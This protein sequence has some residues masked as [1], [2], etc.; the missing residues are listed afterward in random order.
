MKEV[1]ELLKKD[2]L[3]YK[4]PGVLTSAPGY[5]IGD[6][7]MIYTEFGYFIWKYTQYYTALPASGMSPEASAGQAGCTPL[8]SLR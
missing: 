2:N 6:S 8:P 4:E 5:D 7:T 1:L 3:K